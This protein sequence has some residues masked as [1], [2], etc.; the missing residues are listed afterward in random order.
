[1]VITGIKLLCSSSCTTTTTIKTDE[2][3]PVKDA[4]GGPGDTPEKARGMISLQAQRWLRE[5]GATL[6]GDDNQVCEISPLISYA[7]EGLEGYGNEVQLPFC[8]S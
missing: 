3:A 1:M 7:G 5:A 8:L 6:I 4:P 2:F